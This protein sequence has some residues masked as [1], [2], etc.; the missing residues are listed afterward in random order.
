M[1]HAESPRVRRVQVKGARDLVV[2]ETLAGYRLPE[3]GYRGALVWVREANDLAFEKFKA[4]ALFAGAG[5]VKRLPSQEA[6]HPPVPA[7]EEDELPESDV[8]EVRPV[9]AEMVSEL[10]PEL[11]TGVGECVEALLASH[12]L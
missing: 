2:I 9:V 5:A 1:A 7:L 3:P 12:G 10:A 6:Q 8:S 11:R 4:D